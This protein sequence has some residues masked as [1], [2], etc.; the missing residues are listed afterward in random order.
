MSH[1]SVDGVRLQM[2]ETWHVPSC[3]SFSKGTTI[4]RLGIPVPMPPYR[5]M[6]QKAPMNEIPGAH[7]VVQD[8]SCG[9]S[10][11]G[12]CI[13]ILLHDLGRVSKDI[14]KNTFVPKAFVGA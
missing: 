9:P 14:F 12:T 11:Q 2:K 13:R 4:Q 8:R 10:S 6:G 5:A 3:V 7:P 1:A